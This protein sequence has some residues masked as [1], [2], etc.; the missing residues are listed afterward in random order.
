[1]KKKVAIKEDERGKIIK[2]DVLRSIADIRKLS[3]IT[4]GIGEVVL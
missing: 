1:M 4:G 2:M 3:E